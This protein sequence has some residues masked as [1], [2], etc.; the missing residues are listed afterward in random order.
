MVLRLVL[1]AIGLLLA[2]PLPARASLLTFAGDSFSVSGGIGPAFDAMGLQPFDPSL[3]TLERVVVEIEGVLQVAANATPIGAPP[4]PYGYTIQV[5]Q[6]LF[7]L[8]NF[9][10]F[11]GP[12]TLIF[13]GVTSGG[14][15][16]HAAPFSYSFSFT[17]ATDVIGFTVPSTT[18]LT[19]PPPSVAGTRED[20]VED[21]FFPVHEVDFLQTTT[22]LNGAG[23]VVPVVTADGFLRVTYEYTPVDPVPEPGTLALL[24][25]GAAGLAARRRRRPLR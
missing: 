11:S 22:V 12:G 19:S 5:E 3:G 10:E 9:F 7:G 18:G 16:A 17:A 24:G 1:L 20:F 6:L 8:G 25:A 14:P 13:G 4:V 15:I 21:P 2:A 23:L